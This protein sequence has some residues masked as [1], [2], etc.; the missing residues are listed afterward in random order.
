MTTN[1][2]VDNHS[3]D[4]IC[5]RCSETSADKENS[6]FVYCRYICSSTASSANIIAFL[7]VFLFKLFCLWI[8]KYFFMICH[9]SM[10]IDLNTT[11]LQSSLIF[12]VLFFMFAEKLSRSHRRLPPACVCQIDDELRCYFF[13]SSI[14]LRC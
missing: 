4:K 1:S 8:K 3:N 7:L 14:L 10:Q 5:L 9:K 13:L 12:Y 6:N 11:D 2:F